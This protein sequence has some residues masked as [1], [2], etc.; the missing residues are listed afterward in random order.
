MG[1]GFGDYNSLTYEQWQQG[2]G[3]SHPRIPLGRLLD[4]YASEAE[5]KLAAVLAGM[6]NRWP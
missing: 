1:R 5:A 3:S 2:V 6:K 4:A